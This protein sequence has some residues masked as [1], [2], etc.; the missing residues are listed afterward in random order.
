MKAIPWNQN[1]YNVLAPTLAGPVSMQDRLDRQVELQGLLD[2]LAEIN[3]RGP[4]GARLR[5]EI[6]GKILATVK[7]NGDV[8][9]R[10]RALKGAIT[11][12]QQERAKAL[13]NPGAV[14]Q[15]GMA[16]AMRAI[17]DLYFS[18]GLERFRED[19]ASMFA[20]D[21]EKDEMADSLSKLT[22]RVEEIQSQD[23]WK[24]TD[25]RRFFIGERMPFSFREYRCDLMGEVPFAE[26]ICKLFLKEWKARAPYFAEPVTIG[27]VAIR[28]LAEVHRGPWLG[29]YA[30]LKL[31]D[32][33]K[34][35][36]YEPT[37]LSRTVSA[38][39]PPTDLPGK[40]GRRKG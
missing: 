38:E 22:R 6:E 14:G 10:R 35:I 26:T 19:F 17:Q 3:A 15:G 27:G 4:S 16:V 18:F 37:L 25:A 21:L 29:L 23:R 2:R 7:E 1:E 8:D 33:P 39:P 13:R 12:Y 31:G 5:D 36:M 32:M 28:S 20:V 34:R 30:R 11:R 40:F 24:V 9:L